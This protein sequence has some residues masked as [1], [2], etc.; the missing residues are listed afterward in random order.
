MMFYVCVSFYLVHDV[1]TTGTPRLLVTA[2]YTFSLRI[3]VLY[4]SGDSVTAR[5]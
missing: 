5:A 3:N 4:K 2:L 1:V